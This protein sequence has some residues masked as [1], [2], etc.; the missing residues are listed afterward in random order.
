ME[1]E[2]AFRVA[3][4]A[5]FAKTNRHLKD[6]ETVMLRAAWQRKKYDEIAET[7][8]YA[9]E[10]LKHDV[11]PKLWKLL[12]D[13]LGE[14]VSKINFKVA[15]ER[16]SLSLANPD[17]IHLGQ[18]VQITKSITSDSGLEEAVSYQCQDWGEAI[19]V[20]SFY[21]RT[22][23]LATLEQWIVQ[24]GCRLVG[25]LGIGGI[26]KTALSVTSAQQIQDKFEYLIWRSLRHAPPL[27]EVLTKLLRFLNKQ[28]KNEIPDTLDGKLL[29]LIECLRQHRCLLVLDNFESILHPSDRTE[30]YSEA[31]EEYGELLRRIGETSHQSCLVITSRQK[32]KELASLEGETLPIRS[33]QL[34]GLKEAEGQKIF[35]DKGLF[36]GSEAEWKVLIS[37]YSGNPLALKIVANTIQELFNGKISEFLKQNIIVVGAIR[38]LLDRQFAKL[39]DLEKEV[40]YWLAIHREPITFT[41]LQDNFLSAVVTSKLL[42]ALVTLQQSALIEQSS[43]RFTQLPIIMEYVTEQFIELICDEISIGTPVLLN[44]FFL[45]KADANDCLKKIH[46]RVFLK[47]IIAKME[48]IIGSQK[49]VLGKLNQILLNWQEKFPNS[50]GYLAGNIINLLIQMKIDLKKYDF[51]QLNLC[52]AYL[53]N[54]NL[55]YVNFRQSNLSKSVFAEHLG[56]VLSIAFSSNGQILAT[57][58][59]NGE[60]HLWELA[61][62]KKIFICKGHTNWTFSVAFS[63][64]GNI[65]ASGSYDQTIKLWDVSTGQCLKTLSGHTGYVQ[66]IAFSPQGSTLVSS[67]YDQTM[68]LWDVGNGKCLKTLSEDT[69]YIQAIAFLNSHTLATGSQ[70]QTIKLWNIDTGQCLKILQG[71]NSWVSSIAFSP[72]SNI[73]ASSSHDHTIKLWDVDTGQCL[74]TLQGHTSWVSA[75][76]FSPDGHTLASGSDDRTV[77]LWDVDTGQCLKTLR[78]HNSWVSSVAFNP[79][80]TLASGSH[81]QTI[82]LWDIHTS[83]C[84]KTVQGH[85]NRVWSAVFSQDSQILVSG[86]EDCTVKLWDAYTGQSLKILQGHT[87]RVLSVAVNP[88]GLTLASGSEDGTVRLW[89]IDTG[90]CLEI[91]RG[92]TNRVLSVAFAPQRNADIEPLAENS[93]LSWLLAS[94]GDDHTVKLWDANTGKCLNTFYGHTSWVTSVMFNPQGNILAS[95][96][97]DNTV[98]LWNVITGECLNTFHG[99]TSCVSSV[100]FTP[101]GDTLASSSHDRTVKLWDANTG[102]CLKTLAGHTSWVSSVAFAPQRSSNIGDSKILAT[103]SHDQT[104]KLWDISTGQCLKT[105]Q[106]H[107]SWISSIAFAPRIYSVAELFTEDSPQSGSLISTS[108]DE[109]IKVWNI[110]TG[111]C[112]KTVKS[113]KLYEGMNITDTTGLTELTIATL[114][115]LGAVQGAAQSVDNMIPSSMSYY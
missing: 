60:I 44:K 81:D 63:P 25:V 76:A 16:R 43:A 77:K 55:H 51:S 15:L 31:C 47:P 104:V 62:S 78:G 75:V 42:E 92:H 48:T 14:K 71:H 106:G 5:V 64:K 114:K 22:A 87:D 72:E 37:H 36:F 6:V 4:A 38:G 9:A 66:S 102:Q 96:S 29:Q 33:L 58:D 108:L 50:P 107:T 21:G 94:G 49:A 98:K 80:N 99:H 13:A 65:L 57:S 46:I 32:P 34:K 10:Y 101:L 105:L 35:M 28:H 100:A 8:G 40:M 73:L 86:N 67:S 61:T 115:A 12:S 93:P 91:L 56:G 18:A 24:D 74:E 26:G 53:Q 20:S 109:T 17:Q 39:S 110:N 2:E 19:D 90:Q 84:L 45:L 27:K 3:D 79:E 30:H 23:E 7:Y 88:L 95:S 89:D 52:Q 1:F 83:Q 70:D 103:G 54:V 85:T 69:S 82:K 97:D 111:E 68:K 113:D 112:L 41:E 11:G 59:T